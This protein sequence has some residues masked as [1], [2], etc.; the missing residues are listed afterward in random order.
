MIKR[1]LNLHIFIFIMISQIVFAQNR[2][3][4][5]HDNDGTVCRKPVTEIDS[6]TFQEVGTVTDVEGNTYNTVKIGDQWWMAE[7]LKVTKYRNEEPISDV[8]A[9]NDSEDSVETYGRLYSWHEVNK[10][11]TENDSDY[12]IAPEGWHVPKDDE[13]QKL[14]D[15]L[16]NHGH[17]GTEGTALK[18]TTGWYDGGNGTDDY[19]FTG[20]PA[21]YR[22]NTGDYFSMSY[23]ALFWSATKYS[24]SSSYAWYWNLVYDYTIFDRTNYDKDYGFSVRCV[25]D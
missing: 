19:G 1:L 13:W 7:N 9:Y 15:Y 25:R 16:T 2:V 21:G 10:Y 17:S 23:G 11:D 22:T 8:W 20:L 14:E 4:I 24:S 6:V 5:V 3:M 18:S 12:N